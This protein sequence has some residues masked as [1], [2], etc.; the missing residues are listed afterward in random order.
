MRN[1]AKILVVDDDKVAAHALAEVVKRMGFKPIVAHKS[2]DALNIVRLQTVHAALVDV[3]L[4][5]IQGVELVAEFR[6]TKFADNPVIFVSGVFKDKTFIT[7]TLK[8]TRAV[9]FLIKP[10]SVED[11]E[12]VLQKY[13]HSLMVLEKWSVQSLLTKKLKSDRE[14]AKAIEHLEKIEGLDLPFVLSILMEVGSSGHLNIVND[15]GEIFGVTLVKGTISEV[16]CADSQATAILNL[17]SKGFLSQDDW[18]QFQ[19]TAG[20]RLILD[21]LVEEGLVSPHAVISVRHDQIMT[22]VR[23]IC[24]GE[25]LQVNFV[26]HEDGEKPPRHAVQLSELMDMLE[27][28]LAEFFPQSYLAEFYKSVKDSPIRIVRDVQG[29]QSVWQAKAIPDFAVLRACIEQGGTLEQARAE[30]PESEA[31]FYQ[32]LHFLVLN[33][34]VM[35]D[36]PNRAKNLQTTM[37]RFNIL[38]HELQNKTPDRVFEYFGA[39]RNS[40]PKVLQ[41]IFEEYAKSNNPERLGAD[42]TPELKDL[43]RKCYAIVENAY[44]VMSDD[45]KR[46]ELQEQLKS[47]V[48]GNQARAQTLMKEGLELLRRGQAPEALKVLTEAETLYVTS[49]IIFI[50]TWAEIKSSPEGLGKLRLTD[51]VR[52]LD[53]TSVEDKKSPFYFMA[54]G[55]VKAALGD[56][57]APSL[58]EKALDVDSQFAE[59]RRELNRLQ[60]PQGIAP[61]DK[62]LD[63]LNGDITEIVSHIFRRKAD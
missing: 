43:C 16:D 4:P 25:V 17:I 15:S 30:K 31:H 11:V 5:K 62:K 45:N 56:A 28:S 10:F 42:A 22:D 51:L 1:S 35:F 27:A 60:S 41:T 2:T 12:A 19:Q 61:G 23:A 14:R 57:T 52:I 39:N 53:K 33:R 55:L 26:P 34:A 63:I 32:G 58:F 24:G 8:K 9:D 46:Q 20:K 29:A 37:E 54:I 40:A 7:E 59:A 21:K 50:K 3:L 49:R 13:L 36:D 48:A 44:A 38:F 6:N 47:A 18:D